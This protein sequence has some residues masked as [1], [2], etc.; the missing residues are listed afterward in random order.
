MDSDYQGDFF[1]EQKGAVK[2]KKTGFLGKYSE[3]RALPHIRIPVEYTVIYAIGILVLI[4]LAYAVGVEQGKRSLPAKKVA[5]SAEQRKRDTD[6]V[7][8]EVR[9]MKRVAEDKPEK[10][11]QQ[12]AKDAEKSDRTEEV[13]VTETVKPIVEKDV[14]PLPPGPEYVVQLASFR[15]ENN[16]RSAVNQLTVKGIKAAYSRKGDWYQVFAGGY[17]TN[18]EAQRVKI[19]LS[20][21]YSDS[22]I[23]KIK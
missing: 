19:K 21:D 22:Y 5:A 4:I 13:A 17:A 3:R 23:R 12:Q 9:V 10:E 2:P 7:L 18:A 20:D 11:P 8:S 15:D 16:A 6:K 14:K 1:S